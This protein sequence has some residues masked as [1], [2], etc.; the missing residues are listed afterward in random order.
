MNWETGINIHTTV[1]RTERCGKLL[2]NRQLSS[3]LCGDLE[4]W[5][6]CGWEAQEEGYV[7]I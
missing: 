5:I 4:G 2:Y 3:E 1:R 6:R 7:C